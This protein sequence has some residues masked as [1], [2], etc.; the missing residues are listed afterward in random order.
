MSDSIPHIS[1][2]FYRERWLPLLLWLI[3]CLVNTSRATEIEEQSLSQIEE[4]LAEI[5]TRIG[6]LAQM[7]LR[8]GEGSIGY[9]SNP[10]SEADAT[11]WVEIDLEQTHLIDQI[12][13]TPVIW[14]DFQKGFISDAFPLKFRILA[15]TESD[16]TGSV[17]AEYDAQRDA[18]HGIGIAPVIIPIEPTRVSW[19]RIEATQ[20]SMRTFD[21][22]YA[23]E[24]SELLIFSGD[25]NVALH[26]AVK[27]PDLAYTRLKRLSASW[28]KS[29]L[30]DGS[31]PYLMN[32]ATG[33]RSISYLS[34]PMNRRI[35]G[36]TTTAVFKLDLG[37]SYPLDQIHLH[38]IE[39]SNT[40]PQSNTTGAG[41]PPTFTL[42]GAI[43][44]DFSDT[45][46]L[47]DYT[48]HLTSSDD[49]IMMWNIPEAHCRYIRLK[50]PRPKDTGDD[51]QIGFAEIDL[52]SN[53]QKVAR[54]K[55]FTVNIDSHDE[56]SAR[57]IK[58]LT[59]GRNL[60]GN[61]LPIR[62]WLEQLTARQ[63]LETERPFILAE[64][65]QRYAQQKS[66]L[67]IMTWLLVGA[68]VAICFTILIGR[69]IRV[70]QAAQIKERFAADLHDE[71]GA[72]LHTIS[73]LS[74]LARDSVDE[75]DELIGLLD[76]MR[77]M[78]ERSGKAARYCTNILEAEELCENLQDEIEKMSRRLLSDIQYELNIK[79][80][81]ELGSLRT[82][83]RIDLYLFYKESLVNIIRHSGASEVVIDISAS[84]NSVQFVIKDNGTGTTQIPPS[85]ARRARLLKAKITTCTPAGG[86]TSITLNLK[87][88]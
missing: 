21:Q 45:T 61:I 51:F 56:G 85:L 40:V 77:V 9:R 75:R 26:K 59:D 20:L 53:N 44:R 23:L 55:Q 13:L 50:V 16:S 78:S 41:T 30:V 17:L 71:L 54:D 81:T 80:E 62:N 28:S 66:N 70:K 4:R 12:V 31:V 15:G 6:S 27:A 84:K 5:D 18:P 25:T 86:G 76:E 34:R 32:S 57:S 1:Q 79:G 2:K 74:D 87:R 29:Y 37:E 3:C 72:N 24:L 42:E 83:R 38:T 69:N 33:E 39:K 11:E 49:P 36:N 46:L 19:V 88:A 8:T 52:I 7:S 60:Y 43:N 82:K 48:K 47:I 63:G 68:G 73:L 22:N 14:R 65:S 64:I 10:H 67:R 35:K 58:A